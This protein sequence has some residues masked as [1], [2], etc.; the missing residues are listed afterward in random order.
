MGFP[1]DKCQRPQEQNVMKDGDQ[2]GFRTS[3]LCVGGGSTISNLPIILQRC[4][5]AE[6]FLLMWS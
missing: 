3:N 4:S 5:S 1:S 6:L 2:S